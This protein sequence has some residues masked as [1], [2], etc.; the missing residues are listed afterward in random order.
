[1]IPGNHEY[2][3][4]SDDKAIMKPKLNEKIRENVLLVNNDVVKYEDVTFIC[5]TLWSHL[6]DANEMMNLSYGMND[7]RVIKV[8]EEHQQ[9]TKPLTAR[10]YNLLH[11]EARGF[12]Y[13]ALQK[14]KGE[15]IVV[16]THHAPTQLV[17]HPDF[18]GSSINPGFVVELYD[19]IHDFDINYWVYGHTHRNIDT[20][21]N[22]TKVI[23]NQMGYAG[24]NETPE[25]RTDK[26]F[27]L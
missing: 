17:N 12:L 26:Y 15:K 2:Y 24:Y 3:N 20:E 21:I 19:W 7:F 27:E 18:K 13:D 22:G 16:V 5:T 8:K 9:Y 6:K 11:Q 4:N 14:H 10:R 23:S 25:Y 1:M